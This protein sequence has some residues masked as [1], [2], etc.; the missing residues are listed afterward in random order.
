[1]RTDEAVATQSEQLEPLLNR[2]NT[3]T[4]RR[5]PGAH[6]SAHRGKQKIN[7]T[8]GRTDLQLEHLAYLVYVAHHLTL[9]AQTLA[10]F[11]GQLLR[12]DLP[13]A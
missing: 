7:R 5:C 12:V 2:P 10:A 3:K 1:M 6:A 13:M 8:R 4:R 11:L 9:R